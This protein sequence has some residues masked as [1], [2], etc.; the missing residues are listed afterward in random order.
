MGTAQ[1]A[2]TSASW[3]R[4]WQTGN[5]QK[6]CLVVRVWGHSHSGVLP[7]VSAVVFF[8]LAR[9]LVSALHPQSTRREDPPICLGH[10]PAH[11]P[12]L[13]RAVNRLQ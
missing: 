7:M 11:L 9:G 3:L 13:L 1:T 12:H 6:L 4:L 5:V 8:A 10:R 2:D